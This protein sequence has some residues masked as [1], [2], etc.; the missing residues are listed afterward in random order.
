MSV[1]YRYV[2]PGEFMNVP[3]TDITED[4]FDRMPA[5][6][7]RI[8]LRSGAYEP[9]KSEP[10]NAKPVK[11]KGEAGKGDESKNGGA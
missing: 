11:P 5:D 4:Q 9:V 3:A 7:R 6:H 1:K 10:N 2:G 8:V